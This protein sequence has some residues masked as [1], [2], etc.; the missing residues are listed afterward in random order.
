LA[1]EPFPG[2]FRFLDSAY[3]QDPRVKIIKKAVSNRNGSMKFYVSSVVT[4]GTGSWVG[5]EGYSSLG[6]LIPDSHPHARDAITVATCRLDDE[7]QE[8]VQLLKIDVQ[9]GEFG[10][11]DGA[12]QLFD[13]H[14][15]E[16]V[17]AEFMG[18]ER[19]VSFLAQRGYTICDTEYISAGPAEPLR[20]ADW[21][22]LRTSV[23]STGK[24]C[25][26]A[27]PLNAPDDPTA[28]CAWFKS[29]HQRYH[30]LWTDLVAIAPWSRLI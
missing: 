30:S 4:K 3:G 6:Y 10:V 14:G 21:R 25:I 12:Q 8:P 24:S 15:V 17:L 26:V 22:T 18:D 29:E 16:L 2:N 27:T 7:V 20:P 19:I 11:L 9:G 28:Y 13:R 1:F 23:L 5:M